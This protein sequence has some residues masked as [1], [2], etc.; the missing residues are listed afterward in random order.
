MSSRIG[1]S[2]LNRLKPDEKP[3]E[4]RDNSLK[5]FL[6]RV[7]PSGVMTYYCEYL[8][9]KRIRIGR[10]DAVSPHRARQEAKLILSESFVGEDP[11][12]KRKRK[13]ATNYDE[14][15]EQH[16]TPYAKANMKSANEIIARIKKNFSKFFKTPLNEISP[17]DV[18]KWRVQRVEDGKKTATINRDLTTF[19][20][21][22]NRAVDWGII[23]EN[24]I[25]KVKQQKVDQSPNVR[26]LTVAEEGA[27]RDA[28][29]ERE[30][31]IR[32]ERKNA[33]LWRKERG[34]PLFPALDSKPFVDHLKPMVLLSINTGMRRGE[35]FHLQWT[36]VNFERKILTVEATNAKSKQTRHIPLNKEALKTLQDWKNMI[37]DMYD[38]AFPNEKGKPFNN[39]KSSWTKLLKD[40][41][42][43]KFRWHD[44]RHHFA[45]K[46]VMAGVD[47]NTVRELLGHSD[48]QMTLRYAHLAPEHKAAAVEML[49][50]PVK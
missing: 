5:G 30:E 18:E 11:I 13:T 7:Q 44:M 24:P 35:V 32:L 23:D 29:D 33:N 2:L 4:Y 45:S 37:G 15:L 49:N 48:Y 34:Y 25:A 39:V 8:R 43:Q 14:F 40:A 50:F 9:G 42:I 10:V 21:S 41:A 20:A 27:L 1:S 19:K 22:L 3:Y 6:V 28:L 38:L 26:Y 46:L 31:R 16:Y 36:D 17:L 47:L 12:A